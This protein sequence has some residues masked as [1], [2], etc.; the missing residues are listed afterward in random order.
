MAGRRD[1][2]PFDPSMDGSLAHG[3]GR[4]CDPSRC[5]W[6]P[7][8]LCISAPGSGAGGRWSRPG[9]REKI[10]T[11]W[12][13]VRAPVASVLGSLGGIPTSIARWIDRVAACILSVAAV[14]WVLVM[15]VT[16]A[17]GQWRGVLVPLFRWNLCTRQSMASRDLTYSCYIQF[18]CMH[19]FIIFRATTYLLNE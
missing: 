16:A 1:R 9:K 5:A 12:W 6:R 3:H 14:C 15:L 11:V 8:V 18:V 19:S 4:F 2:R 10:G 17:P 13:R 7:V